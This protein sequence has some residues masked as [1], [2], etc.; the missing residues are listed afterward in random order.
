VAV[1]AII[2]AVAY[3]GTSGQIPAATVVIQPTGKSDGGQP[4]GGRPADQPEQPHP[5]PPPSGGLD[6]AKLLPRDSFTLALAP[7]ASILDLRSP[8]VRETLEVELI[9]PLRK[10]LGGEKLFR[11]TTL[12]N[13]LAKGRLQDTRAPELL[14]S[15]IGADLVIALGYELLDHEVEP[16]KKYTGEEAA[17]VKVR[18]EGRMIMPNGSAFTAWEDG[19][20][21]PAVDDQ[22]ALRS[23][24]KDAASP[25]LRELGRLARE[26]AK[27]Q[28]ESGVKSRLA[29]VVE[30][31]GD[32]QA[33]VLQAIF[34]KI[35]AYVQDSLK[36]ESDAELLARK[37]G[38]LVLPDRE[39]DPESASI[40]IP[41]PHGMRASMW[42][43][44]VRCERS[45]VLAVLQQELGA[46]YAQSHPGKAVGSF[47]HGDLMV[48]DIRRTKPGESSESLPTTVAQW[49]RAVPVL[50]PTYGSP[51]YHGSGFIAE[52]DGKW[53]LVTNRHVLSFA[54]GLKATFYDETMDQKEIVSLPEIPITRFLL[55]EHYEGQAQALDYFDLAIAELTTEERALLASKNIQAF[56]LHESAPAITSQV[57]VIGH[58]MDVKYR[59]S[60]TSGSVVQIRRSEKS[61]CMLVQVDVATYPGNSGGPVIDRISG[62]VVSVHALGLKDPAGMPVPSLRFG[63]SAIH[64]AEVAR[65][66]KRVPPRISESLKGE[67]WARWKT[68]RDIE[69]DIDDEQYHNGFEPSL[70]KVERAGVPKGESRLQ[71]SGPMSSLTTKEPMLVKF[72][73]SRQTSFDVAG[74]SKDGKE[75]IWKTEAKQP[76]RHGDHLVLLVW[77]ADEGISE[78]EFLAVTYQ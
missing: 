60:V 21:K 35:P 39:Q 34:A 8:L 32:D 62:K 66:G 43:F 57:C 22:E 19:V 46:S 33:A 38:R 53:W 20:G 52:I 63:V 72:F 24:L 71:W 49:Q 65:S 54:P 13:Q 37:S 68:A 2:A 15:R 64:L 4:P 30:E 51:A 27:E 9:Q 18:L 10:E 44:R 56:Q 5:L 76:M 29:L 61:G 11:E 1:A 70:L 7:D 26:W 78:E 73:P 69:M 55:H 16:G 31:G 12:S 45:R 58:P 40:T 14:P 42:S 50:E 28:S 77:G 67:P 59:N 41:L 75:M 23:A 74:F 36:R 6:L 3:D 48:V 25:M 17:T 47:L